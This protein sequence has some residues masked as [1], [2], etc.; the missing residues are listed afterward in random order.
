[1]CIARASLNRRRFRESPLALSRAHA[2]TRTR[3]AL[4]SP[5]PSPSPSP[6]P[7]SRPRSPREGWIVT[8]AQTRAE[9]R[10]TRWSRAPRPKRSGTGSRAALPASTWPPSATAARVWTRWPAP[11]RRRRRRRTI[12]RRPMTRKGGGS[13]VW[14]AVSA[15]RE[16]C[17]RSGGRTGS[18]TSRLLPCL[19]RMS[20]K[21]V[22]SCGVPS[23]SVGHRTVIIRALVSVIIIESMFWGFF[24]LFLLAGFERWRIVFFLLGRGESVVFGFVWQCCGLDKLRNV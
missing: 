6:T 22:L 16:G 1:M 9:A 19:S 21:K 3:N 14:R 17:S 4:S 23:F 8:R 24:F 5:S 18:W 7:L 11:G 15:R 2:R 12:H 13:A 20:R 10:R